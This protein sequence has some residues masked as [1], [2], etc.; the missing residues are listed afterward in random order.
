MKTKGIRIKEAFV[1]S[2]DSLLADHDADDWHVDS[3]ASCHMF[4]NKALFVNYKV[5]DPVPVRIGDNTVIYAVGKG[6][7][8]ITLAV[9]HYIVDATLHNIYHVPGLCTNLFSTSSAMEQG[10][11]IIFKDDKCVITNKLGVTVAYGVRGAGA[12]FRLARHKEN[13][14]LSQ[15]A[16][17][18]HVPSERDIGLWHD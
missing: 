10:F 3:G 16:M 7:V 6:D 2:M 17:V 4:P 8:S 9:D 12:L 15:S 13:M 14:P 1:A 5:I 18:A 11:A